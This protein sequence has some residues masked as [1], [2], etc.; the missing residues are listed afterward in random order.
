MQTKQFIHATQ[1]LK[2]GWLLIWSP[3]L[4][5]YVC[6]PLLINVL[7][8]A[9]LGWLLFGTYNDWLSGLSFFDRFSDVWLIG[10]LQSLFKFLAGAVLVVVLLFS[11]TLLANFIGAPFNSLLAEKVEAKLTGAPSTEGGS[12]AFLIKSIP[13]TLASEIAKLF[14]LILWMIPI[15]IMHFIPV[16]NILAPLLLFLFGAWMFALE[17]IDYPMGNH[18]LRFGNVKKAL[19]AKR[20]LAMGFGSV[21]ALLSAIPVLNLIVMPWAVASAT[22]LYVEHFKHG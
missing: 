4:R 11:F 9:G 19:K 2:S 15:G 17:Y 16:V 7:V 5:R 13:Q 14:Y 18:G 22:V 1:S 6:L 8:F 21:V 3:G 20:S 12:V 10:K